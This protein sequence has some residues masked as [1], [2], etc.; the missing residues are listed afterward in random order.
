MPERPGTE[1]AE[2]GG[3]AWARGDCYV[4]GP[5]CN[6]EGKHRRPEFADLSRVVFVEK[7]CCHPFVL[8]VRLPGVTSESRCSSVSANPKEMN[9][10]WKNICFVQV[11]VFY[12][13]ESS[14][15]FG[16]ENNSL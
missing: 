14:T 2:V 4:D 10:Y 9:S 6:R 16:V 15:R 1:T 7:G 5:I 8:S 13:S 12:F 3:D 11:Q